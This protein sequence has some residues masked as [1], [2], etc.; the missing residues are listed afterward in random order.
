M[1]LDETT[2]LVHLKGLLLQQIEIQEKVNA[3]YA[4]ILRRIAYISIAMCISILCGIFFIIYTI[5]KPESRTNALMDEVNG[6]EIRTSL[7]RDYIDEDRIELDSIHNL[8]DSMK[9]KVK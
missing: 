4:K 2:G 9:I 6:F 8:I 3:R 7:L 5:N 1:E